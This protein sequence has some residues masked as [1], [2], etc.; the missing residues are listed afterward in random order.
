MSAVLVV[1]PSSLGDIVYALAVAADIRRERP[2]LAIDW[3]AEPGFVPLLAL[4]ADVRR[5]IPFGLRNWRRTPFAVE[6]W[7]DMRAFARALRDAPYDAILDLQEQVKG[8]LIARLARGVRHGFDRASIRE[9][10][11]TLGD[12]VHHRVP[13]NLHFVA[14]CRR[15]AGAALDYPTDTAPR[16]N[17]RPPSSAPISPEQPYVVL[18]HATS[19]DD[20]L[21]PEAHWRALLLACERAGVSSVL[22]WGNAAEEARSRRLADGFSRASVP[23]W[24]SLPDVAALLAKATGAIGVDTGFTHLAA[25]MGTPTVAIFCATDRARHGVS[26]AGAH[27]RDVGDDRAPPTSDEVIAAAAR[28]RAPAIRRLIDGARCSTRCCG[29]SHCR[30]CRCGCGGA[31]G[32]SRAIGCTSASGSDTTRTRRATASNDVLWIH[33]VS[34]GETRAVAPLIER[35]RRDAPAANDPVDA[36]DGDRPRH[37][38]LLFGKRRRAGVAAVRRSVRRATLS[39]AVSSARRAAGR[40]GVVA[41]PGGGRCAQRRAAVADQCA[42][43]RA[44]RARLRADRLTRAAAAAIACRRRG[45]NRG[46]CEATA[47]SG[48]PRRRRQRQSEVRHRSSAGA[49]RARARAPNAVRCAIVP[50]SPLTS[51]R[52]GEEALL[53]DALARAA[54][55]AGRDARRNR[56]AASAAFRRRRCVADRARNSVCA[57]QRRNA[58]ARRRADRARRLDGRDHCV[59]CG[60]RCR[61]CRRK[62]VAA[63]QPQRD[64]ADCRRRADAHRSAY[65]QFRAGE[66]TGGQRRRRTS[67]P[68]CGRALRSRRQAARRCVRARTDAR[69]RAPF[70]RCAS[71]RRRP[72]RRLARAASYPDAATRR[73]SPA[74]GG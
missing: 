66:R 71:W 13:R 38:T 3:V 70:H 9:P 52:E 22:P 56:A 47:G 59:L 10:L 16:W 53:L 18:L 4:C 6:T 17:L 30:C 72:A 27:A 74:D 60:G 25:A 67:R 21:W 63:R 57:A 62:P 23:P 43:V 20:K 26:C 8:A 49:A 32:A 7:R 12:D 68:E 33:A 41:E 69:R 11:A 65:V 24:L 35:L 34:V 46:R 42:A 37:R 51:T 55:I 61:V 39:R 2:D 73:F 40:N 5:V 58:G 36:H 54:R 64:R 28:Y 1:R 29:G 31:A 44:F 14:R 48:R 45:A 19:R 15:L 50:F